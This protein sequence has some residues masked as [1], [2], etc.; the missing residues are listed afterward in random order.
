M[1]EQPSG[2]LNDKDTRADLRAA[3][4]A[5][6]ELGPEMEDHVI[7]AFLARVEQRLQGQTAPLSGST[8]A[9]SRPSTKKEAWIVPVSLVL[10]VPLRAIAGDA[11]GGVGI[12]IVMAA[13][14]L[15]NLAYFLHDQ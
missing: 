3:V 1:Q 5:R 7:E 14:I 8:P 6:R 2:P 9:R 12:L 4:S 11:A 10:A 15:V 13:I